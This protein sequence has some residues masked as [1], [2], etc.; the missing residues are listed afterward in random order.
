L[1]L[2]I[3]SLHERACQGR[4]GRYNALHFR[5]APGSPSGPKETLSGGCFGAEKSLQKRLA[6]VKEV[7]IMRAT[8]T[9]TQV[10]IGGSGRL[11]RELAGN[12]KRLRKTLVSAAR[13]C[14]IRV[15]QLG[16]SAQLSCL[17]IRSS[18]MCGCLRSDESIHLTSVRNDLSEVSNSCQ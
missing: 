3:K 9:V 13:M 11:F 1:I 4:R 10:V 16:P 7:A 8:S 6:R 12:Q 18:N 2:L 17:K 15:P 5:G 14:R